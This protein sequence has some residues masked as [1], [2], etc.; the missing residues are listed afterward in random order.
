MPLPP[1]LSIV[2]PCYN[3]AKSLQ[4]ILS[5]FANF[6]DKRDF[7]LILVN[8]GSTDNTAQVLTNELSKYSFARTVLVAQNQGYGHGVM[9]GLQQAKGEILAFTHGDLQTPPADVFLSFEKWQNSQYPKRTLV[10]GKRTG[11]GLQ[12]NLITFFMGILATLIF[13]KKLFDINGQPKV[14][15]RTLL[16]KLKNYPKTFEFDLFLLVKA[17]QAGFAITTIPVVFN[18]RPH[19]KSH[20]SFSIFSK[21]K[22]ILKMILY[23]FRLRYDSCEGG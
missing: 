21:Y 4:E 19:G 2:L 9:Q 22:T 23:M 10:K 15:P 14:F 3:E 18:K 17:K 20:W 13:Q 5:Q 12:A 8:N 1:K 16:E 7:E 11:R 6:K